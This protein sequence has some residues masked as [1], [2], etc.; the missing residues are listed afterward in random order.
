MIGGN[1]TLHNPMPANE[2]IEKVEYIH[3][4]FD[5]LRPTMP[6]AIMPNAYRIEFSKPCLG[7]SFGAIQ[8][9]NANEIGGSMPMMLLA[10]SE[11]KKLLLI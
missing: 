4:L 11:M 8:P 7:T 2:I 3:T 10:V 5:Q 9:N 1:K 6:T